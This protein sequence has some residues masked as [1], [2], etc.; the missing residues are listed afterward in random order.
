ML[1]LTILAFAQTKAV[2]RT[3]TDPN[4]SPVPGATIRIKGTSTDANGMFKLNVTPKTVLTVSGIGFQAQE[5]TAG[6]ATNL[7]ISLKQTDAS[8]SEV[9]VTALGAAHPTTGSISIRIS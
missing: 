6:D 9:V 5:F 2:T 4:G 1:V 3:I 8:L 7:T